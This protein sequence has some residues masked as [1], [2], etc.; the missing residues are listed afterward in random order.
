MLEFAQAVPTRSR[1]V[2][3]ERSALVTT[4]RPMPWL[5]YTESLLQL[6]GPGRR[7]PSPVMLAAS[8][9]MP[10]PVFEWIEFWPMVFSLFSLLPPEF[11]SRTPSPPLKAMVFSLPAPPMMY[12]FVSFA[13]PSASANTPSPPL[14]RSS[15]V[16]LVP[17]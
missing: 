1:E 12:F 11:L 5:P 4:G 7:G 13:V 10:M 8:R 15:P 16:A 17:T 3:E 2:V 14:P 6:V 9:S